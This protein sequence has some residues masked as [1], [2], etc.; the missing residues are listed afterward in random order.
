MGVVRATHRACY[1][2][3]QEQQA[4]AN[5]PFSWRHENGQCRFR[6]RAWTSGLSLEPIFYAVFWFQG[7]DSLLRWLFALFFV[8][9]LVERFQRRF[10]ILVKLFLS[11]SIIC[12]LFASWSQLSRPHRASWISS[13]G[14]SYGHG[15]CRIFSWVTYILD[16]HSESSRR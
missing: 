12:S 10:I 6:C 8:R 7:D 11:H 2:R 15:D 1:H 3:L 16:T 5:R 13:L 14:L 9:V 4:E